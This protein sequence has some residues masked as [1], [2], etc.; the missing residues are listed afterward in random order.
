MARRAH[1]RF[2]SQI[3]S[4]VPICSKVAGWKLAVSKGEITAAMC[5]LADIVRWMVENAAGVGLAGLAN[6]C[7]EMRGR[8]VVIVLCGRNSSAAEVSEVGASADSL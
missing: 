4:V 8:T 2:A 6:L 3:C 1:N 5:T 7:E